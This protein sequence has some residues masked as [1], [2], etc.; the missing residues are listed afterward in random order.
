MSVAFLSSLDVVRHGA[1]LA[2]L[3][4][5][6]Y[7]DLA[8]GRIPNYAAY[9]GIFLGLAFAILFQ[10]FTSGD[11]I[12]DSILSALLGGGVFFLVYL[13]GG[14]MPGDV[15][16][17]AAVGAL[18]A[19][20]D[21]M[22]RA[23][24]LTSIVGCIMALGLLVWHGQL[25]DGLRRSAHLLLTFGRAKNKTDTVP[26]FTIPYAVAIAIGTMWAWVAYPWG[27]IG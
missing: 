3:I 24:V 4:W 22:V 26:A 1:L 8:R 23:L 16:L 27:R 15:K 11:P 18:A 14:V 5:G 25:I 12:R 10:G 2:L 19:N 21:F 7:S 9:G 20:W 6:A 17:M 13:L